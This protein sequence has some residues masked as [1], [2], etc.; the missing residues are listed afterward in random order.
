MSSR[1][2][3]GSVYLYWGTFCC[4]FCFNDVF[5]VLWCFWIAPWGDWSHWGV[6]PEHQVSDL[7]CLWR[8]NSKIACCQK[9]WNTNFTKNTYKQC[10]E[11][12]K[13]RQW[14]NEIRESRYVYKQYAYSDIIVIDD[15]QFDRN[16][17]DMW[18]WISRLFAISIIYHSRNNK[19]VMVT[20]RFVR[21]LR[22]SNCSYIELV[23][24]IMTK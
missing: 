20:L 24:C 15:F 5:K 4:A 7:Q 11:N 19:P 18:W 23:L 9:V 17:V 12:K 1:I 8:W 16:S 22:F 2:K 14:H 3:E 10:L 21:D 6:C 13:C